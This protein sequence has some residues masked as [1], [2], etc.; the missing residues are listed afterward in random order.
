MK[1]YFIKL[2]VIFTITCLLSGM[3][4]YSE[5]SAYSLKNNEDRAEPFNVRVTREEFAGFHDTLVI[6][7][8][9]IEIDLEKLY[10]SNFDLNT[11]SLNYDE[12]FSVKNP[13]FEPDI[14]SRLQQKKEK[15]IV[16]TPQKRHDHSGIHNIALY[17]SRI[18]SKTQNPDPKKRAEINLFSDSNRNEFSEKLKKAAGLIKN[19]K[20]SPEIQQILLELERIA[21]NAQ[22]LS[23]IAKLYI[24]KGNTQKAYELLERAEKISPD[25][26]KILYTY[27]ICLYKHNDFAGAEKK[28]KKVMLLKPDFM[29]AYYNLGNIYYKEKNYHKAI[30]CFKKAMELAPEKADIYFNI[31]LTLE[32]LDYKKLA[33]KFYS[34]C[35][36]LDPADKEALKALQKLN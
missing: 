31:A 18:A 1:I 35:L 23:N 32:M 19:Q 21:Y 12:I 14:F 8:E 17:G 20:D 11:G 34:K 15:E 27:A 6:E 10:F 24:R 5:A 4:L 30:D 13:K 29:H 9:N 2:S 25:N 36:E 7:N 33:K 16:I 22:N 28:L 3:G 26:F